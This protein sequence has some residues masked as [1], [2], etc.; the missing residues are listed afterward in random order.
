MARKV[1]T[2][3]F[4]LILIILA[5]V[6]QTSVFPLFGFLSVSPN[7]MLILVFSFGFIRGSRSGM[8]YGLI[9]GILT[10]LASGGPMGFYTLIFIW[11]GYLNGV[12]TK[13]YY[14]DYITLPLILCVANELV[15]NLYIFIFGFLIR[16]RLSFGYY[17]LNIVFPEMIFTV[18][19]TLLI[20]RLIL[21]FS[22][23]I[24]QIQNRRENPLG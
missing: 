3:C 5:F 8:F 6:V 16:G 10:D 17:F 1:E 21:F 14:E 20:Y 13:Y 9:A 23:R 11:M 12:F 15:Y 2:V 22:R 7:L 18:V 4:N 19:M 24:T